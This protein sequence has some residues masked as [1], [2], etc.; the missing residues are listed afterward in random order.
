MQRM[1]TRQPS[2][3]TKADE[4][5]S[6]SLDRSDRPETDRDRF[7]VACEDNLAFMAKL[8]DNQMKLVVTSPPYNLGKDYEGQD[9]TRRIS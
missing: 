8:H 6:A 5:I 7:V 4:P 3:L 2:S 1:K 9:V